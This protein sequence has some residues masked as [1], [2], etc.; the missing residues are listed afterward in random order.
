MEASKYYNQECVFRA[1]ITTIAQ[2]YEKVA[3]LYS[4]KV[5]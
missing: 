4:K 1:D 2:N 3:G 5:S